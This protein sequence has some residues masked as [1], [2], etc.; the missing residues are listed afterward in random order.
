MILTDLR[1]V[2]AV[3]LAVLLAAAP[4]GA[5]AQSVDVGGRVDAIFAEFSGNGSP[6]CAL[7]VER[8]GEPPLL[9]AYGMADLDHG[10]PNRP[11]TVFEAGSVAKQFTAAAVLL[12]ASDGRLA[13]DDDVRRYVPELPDYGTPVTVRQLIQHTSG[14]RDWGTVV[15]AAGWPRTTRVHTHDHALDVISRQR[16]LNYAPGAEYSYTNSGYNLLAIIV[17][18][19]SGQ[20]FAGFSE[21]RIFAPLGMRSTRWRDDHTRVVPGRATA[22]ARR[23]GEI[24][25]LMPF[26]NVHGNGGLLTTVEDLLAWNR[27]LGSGTVGGRFL[28]DELHRQGVLNDGRR[29]SY[30]G[31]LMVGEHRGVREVAH[32]GATAGYRAYL[33]RYPDEGLSV[34]LLC[35]TGDANPTRLGLAAAE[36]FLQGRL[37]EPAGPVPGWNPPGSLDHLAGLYRSTRTAGP[38]R[39]TWRGGRLFLGGSTALVALSPDELMAGERRLVFRGTDA[40]PEGFTLHDSDGDAVEYLRV[41]PW[42]PAGAA[43]GEFTGRFRSEEAEAEYTVTE[44]VGALH[45]VLRPHVRIAL[46]PSY[47]D[48]FTTPQGW[49][50]RFVRGADG[51]VTAMS[52]GMGRVRDLRFD[53]IGG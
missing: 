28:I 17:E 18:R 10:V 45:L 42:T 12:L 37:R 52:L 5:Q 35:N 8:A 40:V 30:A 2:S 23:D 38:L 3:A 13:L 34:A 39:L 50:V 33:T 4:A 16:A 26:E 19:V 25:I 22:Y 20:S 7:G 15:A 24:T 9:R 47:A 6:G 49:I 46:T 43:L 41:E 11:Q 21:E 29:I 53:R 27:N 32:S 31:G 14:L 1:S 48:V 36:L 44:E 51:R